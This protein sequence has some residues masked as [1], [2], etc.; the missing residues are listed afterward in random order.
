MKKKK[1]RHIDNQQKFF[2]LKKM[3]EVFRQTVSPKFDKM[4][5]QSHRGATRLQN[6]SHLH[7]KT[8]EFVKHSTIEPMQS[9]MTT[10]FVFGSNK[11]NRDSNMKSPNF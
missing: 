3:D 2:A 11:P 6:K 1:L 4:L 8:G 9:T 5:R 10:Q 7:T